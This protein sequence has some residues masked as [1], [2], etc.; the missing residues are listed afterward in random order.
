MHAQFIA[1]GKI[2]QAGMLTRITTD[3]RMQQ[4]WA[5]LQ[6]KRRDQHVRTHEYQYAARDPAPESDY[7]SDGIA[8]RA[9]WLQ[10]VALMRL[11]SKMITLG[12]WSLP[13]AP[14]SEVR[15]Y[16]DEAVALRQKADAEARAG[17]E[18][19]RRVERCG[20]EHKEY[21]RALRRAAVKAE[22]MADAIQADDDKRLPVVVTAALIGEEL[23]RLF[24]ERL[25]GQAAIIASVVLDR[26][27]T[28][29]QA[30]E[31][32]RG[33]WGSGPWGNEPKKRA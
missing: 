10:Q 22:R 23:K 20:S 12:R 26:E 18:K 33:P 29:S 30:R 2:E 21:E 15:Y 14:M 6:R 4:V 31:Y 7:K 27:V 16:R 32:S 11:Y 24:G 19:D 25:I 8:T 28:P 9:E 17:A 1:L 13:H 5:Y 3:P